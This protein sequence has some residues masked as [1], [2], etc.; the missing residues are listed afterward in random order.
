MCV[1]GQKDIIDF[2]FIRVGTCYPPLCVPPP[3]LT[4]PAPP[5]WLMSCHC[6]G[7]TLQHWK[8]FA[9]FFFAISRRKH[10]STPRTLSESRHLCSPPRGWG[11]SRCPKT[12]LVG[13]QGHPTA[14]WVPDGSASG[15]RQRCLTPSARHASAFR[16]LSFQLGPTECPLRFPYSGGF[17]MD[18]IQAAKVVD[19]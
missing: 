1:R 15:T 2:S 18:W 19:S 13:P 7:E 8:E 9:P 12:S 6:L 16:A 11:P 17:Q 4:L 3:P 10:S 14:K 5:C